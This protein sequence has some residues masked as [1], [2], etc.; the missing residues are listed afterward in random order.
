MPRSAVA[1][2]VVL[3]L[4]VVA[5]VAVAFLYGRGLQDVLFGILGF[6]LILGF[7]AVTVLWAWWWTRGFSWA[8]T[9][10]EK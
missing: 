4:L 9:S 10:R 7:M 3:V 2:V 1:F 8:P 6:F 5:F